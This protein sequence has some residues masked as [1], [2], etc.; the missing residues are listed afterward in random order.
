MPLLLRRTLAGLG[1]GFGLTVAVYLGAALLLGLLPTNR[2]FAPAQDGVE[3]AVTSNRFHT[4]VILPTA[5]AG[6]DWT[7]WC[8]PDPGDAAADHIAFGWGDRAFYLE[9]RRWADVRATTALR[10]LL[11]SSDVVLHVTYVG[12]VAKLGERQ[13][14]MIA[15]DAY[16]RLAEYIR[17]SFRID[18]AGR[19]SGRPEPGYGPHDAFYAAV[20]TYSPFQTCN[21]W[22]AAGLRRAGIRTG[23]WAPF[24]FGI[25]AHL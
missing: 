15:P 23:W 25:T 17:A 7:R 16:R 10:A 3:I 1:L 19:P 8:P 5:A 20:G 21:E 18:A 12:D 22:L 24:A 13:R 6:I 2:G 14:I 4:D 11:F 9:T